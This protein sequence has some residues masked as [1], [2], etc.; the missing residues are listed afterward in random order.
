MGTTH[1]HLLLSC[2]NKFS[3]LNTHQQQPKTLLIIFCFF[4]WLQ[5]STKHVATVKMEFWI[6]ISEIG[7]KNVI[8]FHVTLQ[9]DS[10]SSSWDCPESKYVCTLCD[11]N[12]GCLCIFVQ[13][14]IM[15]NMMM[16]LVTSHDPKYWMHKKTWNLRI[17]ASL[18]QWCETLAIETLGWANMY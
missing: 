16:I 7:C 15:R 13:V 14:S 17:Q 6:I 11:K 8:L 1:T 18:K 4:Y 10:N 2:P 12:K 5:L 9:H 3:L